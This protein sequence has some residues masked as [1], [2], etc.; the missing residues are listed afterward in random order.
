MAI[1]SIS[2]P[3][4][5]F[6]DTDGTALKNGF[7][8]VGEEFKDPENNPI[9]VF[10]DAALTQPASQPIRTTNGY[11]S[12]SG[13]PS[14]IYTDQAYSIQSKDKQSNVVYTSLSDNFFV[15][16]NTIPVYFDTVADMVA[17]PSLIVGQLVITK[18]YF[19]GTGGGN[20]YKIVAAATGTA[21]TGSFIDVTGPD[22]PVQAQ[23]LWYNDEI[24]ILQ[25][26]AD[27]TGATDSQEAFTDAEAY[28][29]SVTAFRLK[30]VMPA[31]I[32]ETSYLP[33]LYQSSDGSGIRNIQGAGIYSTVINY[34]GTVAA[35]QTTTP[36]S[37]GSAEGFIGD[38]ILEYTGVASSVIG[39]D[40]SRMRYWVVSNLFIFNFD[41]NFKLDFSFG[42]ALYNIKSYD[43]VAIGID[44]V[45]DI[46]GV[47]FYSPHVYDNLLGWKIRSATDLLVV[48]G[49]TETNT[50]GIEAGPV[51][52]TTFYSHYIEANTVQVA[53]GNLNQGTISFD[54]CRFKQS[55]LTTD[56]F[57]VDMA[58][59]A[60]AG[61]LKVLNCAITDEPTNE[62][63][64]DWTQGVL[65]LDWFGNKFES[66]SIGGLAPNSLDQIINGAMRMDKVASDFAIERLVNVETSTDDTSSG[67][68][69]MTDSTAAF[70]TGRLIGKII[71]NTTTGATATITANTATT[72]TGTL[73]S[74]TWDSGDG[75]TI[76]TDFTPSNLYRD[77]TGLV[78]IV[79]EYGWSTAGVTQDF[80]ATLTVTPE[81]AVAFNGVAALSAVGTPFT[82]V[83]NTSGR[84]R[85]YYSTDTDAQI[86][87]NV[88]IQYRS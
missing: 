57:T 7:V 58:T 45:S 38:F 73:S 87:Q 86:E 72:V 16:S 62:R 59:G 65:S 21:D 30:L 20:R 77:S 25:F 84:I 53:I 71:T 63:I 46:Q 49:I 34:T 75:Y 12:R 18:E 13:T 8:F 78:T 60:N 6:F 22:V 40:L 24:D 74:G 32:Y 35:F 26:G 48:G 9:T 55:A 80:V 85:C 68:A 50:L 15:N 51:E 36:A 64:I 27:R 4:W 5:S 52:N 37:G 3:Y 56:I 79:L 11:L 69:F 70:V 88:T 47:E 43:A 82:V 31:G 76:P 42:T 28:I 81:I 29:E 66:W 23:A 67:A 41:T 17:A 2:P 19:E 83:V 10:W 33:K 44:L 39:L 54:M 1:E 14:R 61:V